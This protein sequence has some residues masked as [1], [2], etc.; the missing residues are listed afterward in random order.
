[1]ILLILIALALLGSL[2]IAL[3]LILPGLIW[4]LA[5]IACWGYA[6]Y[7]GWTHLSLQGFLWQF[8]LAMAIGLFGLALMLRRILHSRLMKKVVL[9]EQVNEAPSP[10]IDLVGQSGKTLTDMSPR[11][12]VLVNDKVYEAICPNQFIKK[13]TIVTV[14]KQNTFELTVSI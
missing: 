14:T 4:G 9:Q 1:M 10:T 5:G 11:G 12:K 6:G 3:E 7:I 2:L 13:N 8:G